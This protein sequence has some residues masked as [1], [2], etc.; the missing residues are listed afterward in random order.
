MD[1][2]LPD[3]DHLATASLQHRI[4]S[5]SAGQLEQLLDYERAHADRAEARTILQARLSELR[6]GAEPSGGSPEGPRPESAPPASG[7][8]KVGPDTTG[9]PINPPSHGVPSN[10]AQPRQ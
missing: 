5:L 8:G 1:L 10:P 4:R 7:G 6:E 3:Y 2:P 9:P